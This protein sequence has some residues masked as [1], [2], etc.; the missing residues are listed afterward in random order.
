MESRTVK[1]DLFGVETEVTISGLVAKRGDE[2]DVVEVSLTSL[3][4]IPQ[5]V[6]YTR[7]SRDELEILTS[8][9]APVGIPPKKCGFP[10]PEIAAFARDWLAKLDPPDKP[11]QATERICTV[12]SCGKKCDVGKPCWWCGSAP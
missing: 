7:C 1:G 3:I 4:M 11:M 12:A 6:K 9:H 5:K 10:G 2:E 8:T